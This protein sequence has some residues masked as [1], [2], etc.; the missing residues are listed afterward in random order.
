MEAQRWPRVLPLGAIGALLAIALAEFQIDRHA[1]PPLLSATWRASRDALRHGAAGSQILV[2]GDSLLRHGVLP[3][4]L[5]GRLG[6]R[7]YNVGLPGGRLPASYVLVRDYLRAGHRPKMVILDGELLPCSP[8][9]L[10]RPWLELLGPG[11]LPRLVWAAG[12][13]SAGGRLLAEAIIPSLR[14]RAAIRAAVLGRPQD[15]GRLLAV[16]QRNWRSNRGAQ[17]LPTGSPPDVAVPRVDGV[18]SVYCHPA[19]RWY[20]ELFLDL[21]ARH[22]VKVVW[23]LTPL[24]PAQQ[25]ARDQSRWTASYR[26]WLVRL[27]TRHRHLLVVDAQGAGYPPEAMADATHMNRRGALRFSE[28]LADSLRPWLFG[29]VEG[30][31]QA[32]WAKLPPYR[33]PTESVA[34]EDVSQ[35]EA[36]L[37]MAEQTGS[38]DR[39]RR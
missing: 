31:D 33:E 19:N 15:D 8:L 6:V 32:R 9:D 29:N 10:T 4:V 24:H 30:S 1:S 11:E 5:E 20:L 34:I 14:D 36:I 2:L 23:L 18:G 3:R 35:S 16:Y 27:Q 38:T 39:V 25:K 13:G 17:V 28:D 12:D 37:R 21:A 7:A 22:D 26:E